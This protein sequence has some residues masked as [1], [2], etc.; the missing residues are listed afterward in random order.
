MV[1]IYSLGFWGVYWQ[2]L[3]C[4]IG[5]VEASIKFVTHVVVSV[6]VAYSTQFVMVKDSESDYMVEILANH[7]EGLI[8]WKECDEN[9]Y[10]VSPQAKMLLEIP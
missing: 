8:V 9:Y 10:F 4:N 6:S 2:A 5:L 7:L 3:E 1:G